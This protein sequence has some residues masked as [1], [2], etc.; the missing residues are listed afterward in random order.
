MRKIFR[1]MR[2]L[3]LPLLL[4]AGCSPQTAEGGFDVVLLNGRVVDPESKTDAIRSVGITGGRIEAV[5][6]GTLRGRTV[7]DARGMVIAPGFIDLHSHGQDP[8]NYALKAADGVTTALELEVGT[9]DVDKW[10]A[11]REGKSLVNFGSSM[12]GGVRRPG[13]PSPDEG[14]GQ[15][16]RAPTCRS[17]RSRSGCATG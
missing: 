8:A 7:I 4:L 12:H 3:A 2:T 11:E 5:S 10:Y 13:L 6:E 15:H 14:Q 17:R 16:R 1:M 9:A